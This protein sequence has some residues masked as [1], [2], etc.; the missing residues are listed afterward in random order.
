MLNKV[1]ERYMHLC[2]WGLAMG[3]ILLIVSLFYDPVTT[4][5]TDP[6]SL[7]PF[8]FKGDCALFQGECLPVVAYPMTGRI[9]WGMVVPA[10]VVTLVT[11]SHEAWRRLCP[12]AFI[13]QIPRA[14]GWQRK[15]KIVN[16]KTQKVRYELIPIEASSWLGKNRLWV[17]MGLLFL[18]L[19]VR[20]LFVNSDRWALGVFLTLV[21][22]L[23]V[24]VGFLYP[25]KSWCQYFCPMAPVQEVY[26]GPRGLLGSEAHRE[27]SGGISQ[28]MCR[29]VG[30]KGREKSVCVSC[31]SPCMDIDAER[32]YWDR[33]EQPE[34]RMLY[35]GYLGLVL[36]FFLY[37]FFYSG[38]PNYLAGTVWLEQ[39]QLATVLNP[40]F[41]IAGQA[42]PI[43]KLVAVPLT[44]VVF[45][46]VC[47]FLGFGLENLYRR[48]LQ[49][50]QIVLTESTIRHQ[51]FTVFAFVAFNCLYFLGVRP[52]L[53]WLQ[54]FRPLADWGL[55]IAISI[56]AYRS[57]GRTAEQY[58]RESLSQNLRRQL[59]KFADDLDQVLAGRSLESL[60]PDE[61]YI[62]A[63]V[64]PGF[65]HQKRLQTYR[66]V[67][68]EALETGTVNY[69]SSLAVLQGLRQQLDISDTEHQSLI[70]ELG[71][72]D[73]SLLDPD[74]AASREQRLR[75][76][77]YRQSLEM[78]LLEAVETGTP[79][80]QALETKR[81]IIEKFR[82]EYNI[83]AEEDAEVLGELLHQD[84][85][86]H[87]SGAA[88]LEQWRS[89]FQQRHI[90]NQAPSLP[91]QAFL[92]RY[93]EQQQQV[94]MQQFLGILE[95]LG[96]TTEAFN[97][98]R[99]VDEALCLDSLFR[100]EISRP[101]NP[102]WSQRLSPKIYAHLSK[103]NAPT[104]LPGSQPPPT[105]VLEQPGGV[106]QGLVEVLTLLMGSG[107]VLVQAA[108]LW[109]L[110]EIQAPQA[111][112]LAESV[113]QHSPALVNDALLQET[114]KQILGHEHSSTA[115]PGV[116]VSV[117]TEQG[118]YSQRLYQSQI[119]IGR[120]A[121]ND[122]VIPDLQVSRVHA[123]I[124]VKPHQLWI[125]DLGSTNGI[126]L[127]QQV[128][129]QQTQ[130]LPPQTPVLLSPT[131]LPTVQVR[132]LET[133]QNLTTLEKAM[134]LANAQFFDSIPH[135][136]L[137]ELAHVSELRD[138][139]PQDVLCGE[140]DLA[141]DV[142]LLI[143]GGAQA[144]IGDP[145]NPTVLG[146]VEVGQ[147][148]G[149]IGVISQTR[150]MATVVATQPNTL[151]L[152]IP[153]TAFQGLLDS[154][155]EFTR[156]ILRLMTDRLQ[157]MIQESLPR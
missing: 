1:P 143:A 139:E 91:T 36:G 73:P 4:S 136:D 11:L 41:F 19:V 125:T 152:A 43:P 47:Y 18:G 30:D 17:Q 21:I 123:Q 67:L 121:S 51:M 118:H 6:Q 72:G 133:S 87:R 24:L 99:Q 8:R 138:Y 93:L 142:L 145:R 62:L 68:R 101:A 2:R 84:S 38:N 56:W 113:L 37:F 117:T 27:G 58:Q 151:A 75:I 94:V 31:Q 114:A 57:L 130:A 15:R 48:Y 144:Q 137:I 148:L 39:Q 124:E 140:G 86:F 128:F 29:S 141:E 127:N 155:L 22:L 147:T 7:S 85:V 98:V 59:K 71:I 110:A 35:Y 12:L 10:V 55:V 64:L 53:G 134:H 46:V 50:N 115:I 108:S 33:V 100:A 129:H 146:I 77:G 9:F 74:H 34:R 89:L 3:W 66:E 120:E 40:G 65:N 42:L 60:K 78:I 157:G 135:R 132:W 105:P 32:A 107:D 26:T 104:E 14:L 96:D 20:L 82:K 45:V 69:T 109:T 80:T 90:L 76:Q 70:Q 63:K 149:E 83:T 154:D 23:A 131:G 92:G 126:S 52:T 153:R 88:L 61:V 54:P 16:P 122:V 97:L 95:I 112:A 28:S 119:R 5:W 156:E 81:R 150:R 111:P 103:L 116:E 106:T 49:Q 13:S 79:L 25:G 102:A 44:L